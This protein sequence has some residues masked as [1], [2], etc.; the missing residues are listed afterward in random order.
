LDSFRAGMMIDTLDGS[1]LLKDLNRSILQSKNKPTE[2]NDIEMANTIQFITLSYQ[3]S[4]K[5]RFF[6]FQIQIGSSK[7]ASEAGGQQDPFA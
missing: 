7:I 1:D 2:L 6:H 5:I 3:D 4:L